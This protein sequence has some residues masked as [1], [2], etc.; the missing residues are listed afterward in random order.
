M[1]NLQHL[2]LSQARKKEGLSGR[3]IQVCDQIC[4][5]DNC[6]DTSIWVDLVTDRLLG[7]WRDE[8]ISFVTNDRSYVNTGWHP[9]LSL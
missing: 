9:R 2:S 7:G 4:P 3:S 5:Q 1:Y 6:C 8:W